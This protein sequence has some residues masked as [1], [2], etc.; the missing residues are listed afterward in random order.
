MTYLI[1]FSCYGSRIH[2]CPNGSVDREHNIPGSPTLPPTPARVA[3]ERARMAQ[4]PYLLGDETSRETVLV[5]IQEVCTHRGWTLLAAHVRTTHVHAVVE[6]ESPPEPILNAFKA[7]ATRRLDRQ[8]RVQSDGK[9]WTRH[10]STRYLR[11]P[12]SINAAIDYVITGQGKPMSVHSTPP[13]APSSVKPGPP[14]APEART[15]PA[16]PLPLPPPHPQT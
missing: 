4:P 2:G 14:G 1:T 12:V 13:P 5:A 11:N 16:K 10:G 6:A 7:Y 8:T 9:R 15:P 3:D